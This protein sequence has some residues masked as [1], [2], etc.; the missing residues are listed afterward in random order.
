M[1]NTEAMIRSVLSEYGAEE[2]IEEVMGIFRATNR[3]KLNASEVRTLRKMHRDGSTQAELAERFN[4]NP[5][6]VSRIVRRIYY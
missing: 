4:V 3:K 2:A 5:A 1:S 6:T